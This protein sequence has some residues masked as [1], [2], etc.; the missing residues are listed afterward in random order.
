MILRQ[1]LSRRS[2]A[3]PSANLSNEATSISLPEVSALLNPTTI[4]GEVVTVESSKTIA[5]AYRAGNLLSDAFALM[6]FQ[7]FERNGRNVEQVGADGR[8]MNLAYLLE[9]SPNQWGWTPFQFKKAIAQWEIWHGN[10][11][12]WRPPVWPP[13]LLILPANRTRP[14]F[15]MDGNLWYEHRFSNNKVEYIPSVEILHVLINPDET[16]FWGR[17]IVTFARETFG[18]QQGA[19]RTQGK[20]YAQGLNVAAYMQFNAKLDKAG[21]KK[22]RDEYESAMSGSEN[23]YRLA[24]M[25]ASVTKFEP[26]QMKM[27]DAQFLE[28]INATNLD[29]ANFFGMPAHMLNMGKEAYNSNEQK[30]LEFL[31]TTLDPYLVPFEQAA[32]IRWLTVAEQGANYFKFNRSALLRMDSKGRA[33]TNEIRIRS[34]Q[35]TPNEAREKDD[36]SAYLEGD[37][38]Y[39]TSNYAPIGGNTNEL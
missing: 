1:A 2:S 37:R 11:I 39:M 9:V 13:Q 27:T 18:R 17:G 5:T 31:T 16:G 30:Y 25:D 7:Q 28:Q 23:A 35:M 12:V 34:G 24:V 29:I 6:P 21:R 4:S 14:V 38:Y 20:M 33:E 26:I 32:R 3:I 10:A 22:I 8:M 19:H 15:D 36:A